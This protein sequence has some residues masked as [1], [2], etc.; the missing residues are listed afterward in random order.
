MHLGTQRSSRLTSPD[1]NHPYCGIRTER[2]RSDLEVRT[3]RDR[4]GHSMGT[5]GDYSAQKTRRV[6]LS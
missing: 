1:D 2:N 3:D 5:D 4:S 6:P